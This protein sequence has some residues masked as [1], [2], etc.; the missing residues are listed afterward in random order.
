M[1]SACVKFRKE[2]MKF[3]SPELYVQTF[4]LKK[5]A[6]YSP[7]VFSARRKKMMGPFS[8]MLTTIKMESTTTSTEQNERQNWHLC[9][10][11]SLHVSFENSQSFCQHVKLHA[12]SPSSGDGP[13]LLALPKF[14]FSSSELTVVKV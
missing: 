5:M 7:V 14:N 4:S 6:S 11:M 3:G 9:R 13:D 12:S 2:T 1:L 10:P 8:V